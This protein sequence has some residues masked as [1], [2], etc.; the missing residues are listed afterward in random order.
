M[1]NKCLLIDIHKGILGL[2]NIGDIWCSS[3][4]MSSGAGLL[5][6]PAAPM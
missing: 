6:K 5:T 1:F 2:F 4:H 3:G